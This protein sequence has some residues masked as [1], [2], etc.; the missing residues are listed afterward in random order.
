MANIIRHL[1]HSISPVPF[2]LYAADLREGVIEQEDQRKACVSDKVFVST[3]KA[4]NPLKRDMVGVR[5]YHQGALVMACRMCSLD[6]KR[7]YGKD[8]SLQTS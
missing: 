8:D 2:P 4:C 5:L 3:L 7:R 6:E 1:A